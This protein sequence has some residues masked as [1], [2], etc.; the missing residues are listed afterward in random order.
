MLSIPSLIC[1]LFQDSGCMPVQVVQVVQL[2]FNQ[3][4]RPV[5]VCQ[6][7]TLTSLVYE[8]WMYASS[9]SKDHD[10]GAPRVS[11]SFISPKGVFTLIIHTIF[12]FILIT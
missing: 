12:I 3:N 8:Q 7:T 11:P 4:T 10:P 9:D 5:A 1:R 2:Q 6:T